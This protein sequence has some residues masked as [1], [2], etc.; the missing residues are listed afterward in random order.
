MMENDLK[1]LK[2]VFEK[3]KKGDKEAFSEIFEAYFKPV[4][5]YVY[6]RIGNK[7]ES[8]D[9]IQDIF[10]KAINSAGDSDYPSH[11]IHFYSVAKKSVLD[12]KRKRRRV[13]LSDDNLENYSSGKTD[14][15]ERISNKEEFDNLHKAIKEL[16]DE[17]QDAVILKFID[18][19]S[20][21]DVGAILGVP[22]K[23]ALH[24]QAQG[25]ILI[26][27]ILKQQYESQI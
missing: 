12:W 8:D 9:L 19:F 2:E 23:S 21:E 13:S 7:V 18:G 14:K 16:P 3:A 20:D 10:I 26:R 1:N 15:P 22:E 24:L 5:R 27:D 11:I 4:Y 25:L 17:Y 6:F